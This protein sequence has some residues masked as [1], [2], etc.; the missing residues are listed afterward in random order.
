VL[1]KRRL[2]GAGG[3]ALLAGALTSVAP[4][5][6]ATKTVTA[7]PAAKLPDELVVNDFFRNR[8]TVR[9]GD[10]V[11]WRFAGFHNVVFPKKGDKPP[12]LFAPDPANPVTGSLDAA[13][14]P[15]FFNGLP[16]IA[17]EPGSAFPQGGKTY[18]G[19]ALTGSGIPDDEGA[20]PYK[21]K[22]PK[23]GTYTY[24]CTIHP[25]MKGTVKV[26]AKSRRVPSAAQD[27]AAAARQLRTAQRSAAR[28]VKVKPPAATVRGGSDK[29]SV[30]WLRFF[31]KTLSVKV[32][33][34]VTVTVPGTQEPHTFS[35]GPEAYL[36]QIVDVQIAPVP[37][38]A[39]PPTLVFDPRVIY[40]S[41]PPPFP[42]VTAQSHGNGFF[43][44]GV[45]G[46]GTP[47]GTSAKISFAAAGSYRYI[48]L[49][50]P[51]MAGTINV[52]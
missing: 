19:S 20:K 16:R 4:A 5:A 40:P 34:P 17:I 43:S 32:G 9:A 22:F 10:S 11:Q 50:H 39:G 46:K 18:D 12:G 44:T 23:T 21:L 38:P 3:L 30:A 15:F 29:G 1:Q 48:C 28:L 2:I 14:K 47:A 7:G 37:N 27:R 45:L 52:Q 35:F 36:K 49:I 13:G 42:A 25:G 31:P 51:E 8:V 26:V 24:Y 6:A 33:Q 41:D